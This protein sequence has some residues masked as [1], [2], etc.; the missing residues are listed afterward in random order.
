M[1]QKLKPLLRKT[2]KPEF[3]QKPCESK[4]GVEFCIIPTTDNKE[5]DILRAKLA[6]KIK[7]TGKLK[8]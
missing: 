5:R 1:T 8:V 4:M 7:C 2:I 3:I 6:G